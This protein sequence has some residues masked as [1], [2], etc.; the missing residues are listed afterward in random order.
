MSDI[1]VAA[2]PSQDPV[3]A[4]TDTK[5]H[6]ANVA[7]SDPSFLHSPPDSNNTTKSDAS[8]SELSDLED[9]PILSDAP[10]PA[11]ASDNGDNGNDACDDIGEVLPDHWSGTVPVFKPTMHQ[12]K[13]F[14]RFVCLNKAFVSLY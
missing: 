13:D 11:P 8:D 9:E 3:A 14:K 4:P 5:A 7:K 2:H 1:A 6:E 10:Q 12:F